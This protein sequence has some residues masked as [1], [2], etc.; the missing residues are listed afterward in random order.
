MGDAYP[1][2]SA[3]EH[4]LFP[5]RRNFTTRIKCSPKGV[6]RT[7]SSSR[8]PILKDIGLDSANIKVCLQ[9]TIRFS[10]RSDVGYELAVRGYNEK[11]RHFAR[12]SRK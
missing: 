4:S 1:T 10:L 8:N 3:P 5:W 2:G 9:N 7:L 12:K 11:R 6:I